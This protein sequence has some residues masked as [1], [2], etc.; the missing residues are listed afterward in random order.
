M[1][2]KRERKKKQK[3]RPS[4]EKRK[5]SSDQTEQ[6][7]LVLR[8]SF[9]DI[10]FYSGITVWLLLLLM[11]QF[12]HLF[13]YLHFMHLV[14]FRCCGW[15]CWCC[16]CGFFLSIPKIQNSII[17]EQTIY[18]WVFSHQEIYFMIAFI[19]YFSEH[20]FNPFFLFS[21]F[22]A[23]ILHSQFVCIFI[24]KSLFVLQTCTQKL[25]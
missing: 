9:W 14:S 18:V 22:P 19:K 10:A 13:I 11:L 1:C 4:R 5:K 25:S 15:C 2:V 12:L 7:C 17:Y 6:K 23:S 24:W 3:K 16:C 21:F 20:W 8:C